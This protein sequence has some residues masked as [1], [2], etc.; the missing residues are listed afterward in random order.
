[1]TGGTALPDVQRVDVGAVEMYVEI[2]GHGP[3]LVL[4]H[5]GGGTIDDLGALRT[6]LSANHRVVAPEQRGHGRTGDP[7]DIS[8]PAMAADTAALLDALAVERADLVGWSDGAVIALLV[9]RDRPDLVGSVVSIGGNVDATPPATP[10]F[11]ESTSAW[12]ASATPADVPM[13]P[14]Y[15]DPREGP[16]HWPLVAARVLEM[17]RHDPG[18]SLDDLSRLSCPVLFVSGDRDMIELDHTLAMYRAA[19]SAALAIVPH[20]GHHV[21]ATH[22]ALVA[23]LTEQFLSHPPPDSPAV[24]GTQP[25]G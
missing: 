9:A 21:P 1:M 4:L 22:V 17:W 14:L 5:G 24:E 18:L 11:T 20:A 16:A 7:G 3:D 8:Y 13:P 2:T 12:L 10:A 23:E 25:G 15:R 6:L 19:A